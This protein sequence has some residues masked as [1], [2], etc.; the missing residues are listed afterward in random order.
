MKPKITREEIIKAYADLKEAG[1]EPSALKIR[2][3]L[4][5]QGSLETIQK[6]IDQI[7]NDQNKDVDMKAAAAAFD[8]CWHAAVQTGEA[9]A[10]AEVKR[11]AEEI[12]ALLERITGLNAITENLRDQLEDSSAKLMVAADRERNLL[13]E[14]S[15]ARGQ[16]SATALRLAEVTQDRQGE[17]NVLRTQL[18][19][20]N[21][22]AHRY[23]LR[24]QQLEAKAA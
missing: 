22:R 10:G 24:A 9:R 17:L 13:A 19:E 21:G 2:K 16:L 20:A 4:G 12:S 3:H 11:Q 6:V 14:L 15:S 8:A 5:N 1:E 23:E 18:E 7:R